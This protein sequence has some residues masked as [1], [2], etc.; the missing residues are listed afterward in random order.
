MRNLRRKTD[1]STAAAAAYGYT[2][3]SCGGGPNAVK[4]VALLAG[5]SGPIATT[6]MAT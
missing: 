6:P 5:G 1:F 3:G 4:S 2:G